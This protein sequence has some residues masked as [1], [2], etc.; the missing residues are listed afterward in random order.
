MVALVALVVFAAVFA[1]G[2]VLMAPAE[3][4]VRI[5][6]HL[7]SL[8]RGEA[9]AA[10]TPAPIGDRVIKPFLSSVAEAILRYTPKRQA[11]SLHTQIARAGS[12]ISLA[13]FI[14]IR[15]ALALTAVIPVLLGGRS[16]LL[17]AV[18]LAL[19][20]YRLPSLWLAG[21]IKAR[22]RLMTK[23]LP[24]VLD[25]IAVSVEAGLGFDGALQR[26]AEKSHPPLSDELGRTLSEIRLGRT[27]AEALRD[28]ATRTDIAELRQV[29]SAIIQAEQMGIGLARPLRVESDALRV[30][31]RQRAEEQA[32]KT[33]VKLL[34]PLVFLIF[35]ALFI[36]LL[37]PAV[38]GIG[39]VLH[40]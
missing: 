1:A 36:V 28:L 23:A 9:E 17:W 10:A 21:R 16:G 15:L 40:P 30:R 12:P 3:E 24:D 31:R 11:D 20:G 7:V 19:L 39:H 14:L 22:K 27:R 13:T 38:L 26:V 25:L 4:T 8:A 34:F 32:M 5:Q 2:S 35:P 33:P 29:V 18:L 6:R 37:G